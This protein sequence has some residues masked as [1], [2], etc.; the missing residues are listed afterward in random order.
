MYDVRGVEAA[1]ESAVTLVDP[2]DVRAGVLSYTSEY[3]SELVGDISE[4]LI[5]LGWT[6]NLVLQL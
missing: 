1:P 3:I 4:P 6:A 5:P 2:A